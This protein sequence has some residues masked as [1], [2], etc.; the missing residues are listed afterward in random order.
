MSHPEESEFVSDKIYKVAY[1]PKRLGIQS[2]LDVELECP[3]CGCS[4]WK[5]QDRTGTGKL[6]TEQMKLKCTECGQYFICNKTELTKI[7][8]V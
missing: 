8:G 4:Q 6:P 1:R 5:Y 2:Y 3:N 7:M